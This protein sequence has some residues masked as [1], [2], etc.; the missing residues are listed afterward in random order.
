MNRNHPNAA[1]AGDEFGVYRWSRSASIFRHLWMDVSA[2]RHKPRITRKRQLFIVADFDE[3][4][5][6]KTLFNAARKFIVWYKNC[7][8]K[9][10][11][12]I[13]ITTERLYWKLRTNQCR[14]P[15]SVSRT[16]IGN[17]NWHRYQEP[18]LVPRTEFGTEN[19][20]CSH[21]LV[22]PRTCSP[23]SPLRNC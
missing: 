11:G 9:N 5:V 14:E 20:S 1:P 12:V 8:C 13:L 18:T 15:K 17:K 21:E 23:L 10:C 19:S 2:I 6:V 3:I 4:P 16:D 7:H 22:V